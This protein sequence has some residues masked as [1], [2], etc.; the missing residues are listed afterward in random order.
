MK[1]RSGSSRHSPEFGIGK[2]RGLNQ[3][4]RDTYAMI[5]LLK[6]SPRSGASTFF[7]SKLEAFETDGRQGYK[8][9]LYI[10]RSF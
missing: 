3:P 1:Q 8:S 9:T 7:S 5:D 2:I 10:G 6:S 4:Q